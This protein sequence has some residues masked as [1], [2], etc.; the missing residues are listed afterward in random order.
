MGLPLIGVFAPGPIVLAHVYGR[1]NG[2]IAGAN[3]RLTNDEARRVAKLIARLPELVRGTGAV[4]VTVPSPID[5]GGGVRWDPISM[6]AL[7]SYP[8]IYPTH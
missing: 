7:P 6:Q 5:A 1:P 8:N 3:I 4:R 2:A